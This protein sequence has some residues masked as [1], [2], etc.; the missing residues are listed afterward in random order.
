MHCNIK[1]WR[2]EKSPEECLEE[3]HKHIKIDFGSMLDEYPE[4]YFA[5]KYL[6]DNAKVLELG[7][8]IGRNSLVISSILRYSSNLVA[9]ECSE[10]FAQ[11]LDHNRKLNNSNFN[12]VNAAISEIELIQKGWTTKKHIGKHVPKGWTYVKIVKFADVEK[13]YGLKFDTLVVDCEGAFYYILKSTP[14]ILN[15]IKM[16]IMENDYSELSQKE[17]VDKVLCN[18]GFKCVESMKGDLAEKLNM[19]CFREFYQVFKREL[20]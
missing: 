13:K 4:Q 11:Q 6:P 8:N 15:N 19:P 17:Y 7:A 5:M 2:N 18:Y 16:I 1:K 3:L 12:I 14:N 9:V 10:L 20:K